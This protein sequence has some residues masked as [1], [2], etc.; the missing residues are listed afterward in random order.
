[1]VLKFEIPAK[2]IYKE[3]SRFFNISDTDIDKIRI[4]DKKLCIKKHNRYKHYVFCEDGNEHIPLKITFIDALGYYNIFKGDNK[5]MNFKLNDN[6]LKNIIDLFDHIGKIL[7]IDHALDHYLYDDNKGITY[8]KTKV[9]D[10]TFLEK[11]KIKQIIQFQMKRLSIIVEYYY[12][13]SLFTTIIMKVIILKYFYKVVD[14]N[15]LVIIDQFMML[16]ILQI[17]S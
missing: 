6:S 17:L 15:F 4:S 9:S 1:M 13:Y 11:T 2:N 16:L 12:K 5:T 8:L 10:E 7:N 14:I 3:D